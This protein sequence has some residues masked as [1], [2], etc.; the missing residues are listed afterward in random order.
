MTDL[1]VFN[2]SSATWMINLQ[3][4]SSNTIGSRNYTFGATGLDD[5]PI[6]GDFDGN[7]VTDTAVF[8]PDTA[9]WL[10]ALDA[11][12]NAIGAMS[13]SFGATGLTDIP[14]MAPIAALK[15]LGSAARRA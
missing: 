13:Y 11:S 5:I 8:R 12:G 10:I 2:P 3:D 1:A 15:A 6:P 7:G 9:Q 14:T 4:S